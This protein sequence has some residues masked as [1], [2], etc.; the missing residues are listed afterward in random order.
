MA[1]PPDPHPQ[2]SRQDEERLPNHRL[3]AIETAHS[4][5]FRFFRASTVDLEQDIITA[6]NSPGT[7][8]PT[9]SLADL[10]ESSRNGNTQCRGLEGVEQE[11]ELRMVADDGMV[12]HSDS[13]GKGG[14]RERKAKVDMGR[15]PEE[16][17]IID[18]RPNDPAVS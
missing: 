11:K 15:G 2:S 8:T 12:R 4:G 7:L 16:V 3:G 1:S 10:G 6:V 18:W 13:A 9:I 5:H 14:V 17:I